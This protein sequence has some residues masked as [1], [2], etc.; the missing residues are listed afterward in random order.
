MFFCPLKFHSNLIKQQTCQ[1]D[2]LGLNLNLFTHRC[3]GQFLARISPIPATQVNLIVKGRELVGEAKYLSLSYY[4]HIH[5]ITPVWDEQHYANHKKI[6]N[7]L[8]FHWFPCQMERLANL[9]LASYF[10][11]QVPGRLCYCPCKEW[12]NIWIILIF[13]L[14]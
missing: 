14:N 9:F 8:W 6:T 3:L 12:D 7:E 5:Q 10:R 4:M 11:I 13:F 2:R 1:Q